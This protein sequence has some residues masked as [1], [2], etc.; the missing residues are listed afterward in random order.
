LITAII[1]LRHFARRCCCRAAGMIFF[2]YFRFYVLQ[3]FAAADSETP[4]HA[5]PLPPL[6]LPCA[7]PFPCHCSSA[8]RALM[9]CH[10]F[11]ITPMPRRRFRRHAIAG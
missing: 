3:I 1:D 9:P 5:M 4:R 8:E 6:I 11:A 7:M 10:A 2:R